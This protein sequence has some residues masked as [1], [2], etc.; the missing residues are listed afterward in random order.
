LKEVNGPEI[1]HAVDFVADSHATIPINMILK[2]SLA[3]RPDK[4]QYCIKTTSKENS[5]IIPNQQ[6]YPDYIS[7][8]HLESKVEPKR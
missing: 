7:N 2:L 5:I 6:F 4:S 8:T 1:N 3:A